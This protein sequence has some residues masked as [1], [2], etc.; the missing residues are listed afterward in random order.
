M[1]TNELVLSPTIGFFNWGYDS[2]SNCSASGM[3]LEFLLAG[4]P[5]LYG[6]E[7]RLVVPMMDILFN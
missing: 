2:E 1:P 3:E 6:L 5:T 7:I 4:L